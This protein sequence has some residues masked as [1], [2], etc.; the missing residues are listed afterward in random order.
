MISDTSNIFFI[1]GVILIVVANVKLMYKMSVKDIWCSSMITM[2][3]IICLIIS[4]FWREYYERYEIN[5][6][7]PYVTG[8]LI[9]GTVYASYP[10]KT[11]GLGWVM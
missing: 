5:P 7:F 10:E 1:L 8:K 9:G 3:G 4:L 2:A 6:N 11:P